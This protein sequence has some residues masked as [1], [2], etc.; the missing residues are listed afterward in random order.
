MAEED[1]P[2]KMYYYQII[3]YILIHL[4]LLLLLFS[5]DHKPH[6][7]RLPAV[8]PDLPVTSCQTLGFSGEDQVTVLQSFFKILN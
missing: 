1:Y 8:A 7:Q 5:T 2:I 4:F 6:R 3:E